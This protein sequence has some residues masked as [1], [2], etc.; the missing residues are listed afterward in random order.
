MID[1]HCHILPSLCDGSPDINT[2]LKMA[3]IAVNDGITI[4]ACTP[5][6][7]PGLYNNNTDII[8]LAME[9]LQFELNALS[10]P[11]KLVVGAD[12]HM[13][14]E[15][16]GGL[17]KSR[18]PTLNNSRYFLLE[19]NHHVPVPRFVEQVVAF[20]RAGF[21]PLITHPERLRWLNNDSY[22]EFIT[23]AKMGA[24]IQVTA[25]AIEGKFGRQARYWVNKFLRS[26][27]VH[28]IAT[29][30]HSVK[31]RPPVLSKA[32]LLAKKIV[33]SEEADRMVNARAQAVIDNLPTEN[34][35]MPLALRIKG[36]EDD[37][38]W[39]QKYSLSF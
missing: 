20:V 26:G 17:K 14:P 23:A 3:E 4:Q 19:P 32:L 29:D 30:A 37:D 38:I 2:S 11:L 39:D 18:I 24:W 13:V 33:G 34:I 35:I 21:I 9:E 6:I 12:V 5:H 28:I 27:V 1:L 25:G 15:V 31:Y 8:K 7:Y 22:S 16:I 36:S 10:I